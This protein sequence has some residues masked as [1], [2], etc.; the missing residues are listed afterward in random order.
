MKITATAEEAGDNGRFGRDQVKTAALAVAGL[1]MLIAAR[2]LPWVSV[3]RGEYAVDRMFGRAPS[4]EVRTFMLTDL[5]GYWQP[6]VVGWAALLVV[7]VLAW[8]RPVWRF[9][10]RL[11]AILLG[12]VLGVGTLLPATAA[13]DVSGFPLKDG[14]SADLLGGV[15]PAVF[16]VVLLVRA[17]LVLPEP[18]TPTAPEAPPVVPADGPA[19]TDPPAAADSTPFVWQG[20]RRNV[21]AA[22]PWWRR[23]GPVAGVV[24]GLASA[25][26]LV[27]VV[28]YATHPAHVDQDGGL[29][30]LVVGAPAGSA[31]V[32]PVAVDDRVDL[33][34]ILPLTDERTFLLT[35]QAGGDMVHVAGSAWKRSDDATVSITLIQFG[36]AE[37]ADQFQRTYADLQRA[38]PGG[39][40]PLADVPGA[41]V[42]VAAGRAGAW[43][44]AGRDDVVVVVSAVGGSSDTAPVVE[45]LVREQYDRL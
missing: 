9:G 43:G 16:G 3:S 1:A 24:A 23:P 39:L 32:T 42:F 44:L 11:A 33:G 18:T 14:P 19:G 10:L 8:V 27:T 12:V 21:R 30:A 26:V 34:R 29:G 45:S 41:A 20:S 5:P 15:W 37:S 6:L 22:A 31:P 38:T 13:I 40:S 28:W 7:L 36:S 25:A 17:V 2:S 35:Q 4:S